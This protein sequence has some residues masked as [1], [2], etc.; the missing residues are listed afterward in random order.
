MNCVGP[1]DA[2]WS[3]I[4]QK[5]VH[6]N[7]QTTKK[8]Q[9]LARPELRAQ[10]TKSSKLASELM[11]TLGLVCL[12]VSIVA[13]HPNHVRVS[14]GGIADRNS[15]GHRIWFHSTRS[16]EKVIAEVFRTHGQRRAGGTLVI[17]AATE[18]VD[19]LLRGSARLIGISVLE[20]EQVDVTMASIAQRAETA[21]K[22]MGRQGTMKRLRTA[23]AQLDR[24]TELAALTT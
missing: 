17:E 20:D 16:A 13:G 18:E 21:I 5:P 24:R 4:G 9:N 1:D 12:R 22:A 3:K 15:S 8:C 19:K 7:L 10:L 2:S 11:T 23:V 6:I 14:V